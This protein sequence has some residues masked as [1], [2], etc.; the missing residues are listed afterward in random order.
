MASEPK[1]SVCELTT[2]GLSFDEEVA[3]YPQV[4]AQGIGIFEPK[5]PEGKDE[6]SLRKLREGGLKATICIPA[7]MS[8]LPLVK[9][10][11]PENPEER[12][13][14]MCA[15]IRRLAP[16]EPVSILC[17]TGAQGR[18][19]EPEARRIVVWG[20]R[21]VGRVAAEVGVPIGLEPLHTSMRED[22]TIAT[23]I[24]EAVDI[25]EEVGDPGFGIIFDTWHLWDTPNLYEDIRRHGHRLVRAI[26]ID[27]WRNTTRG[28]ND[29]A[30]PGEGIVDLPAIFGA[31]ESAGFDGWYDVEIFSDDGRFENDY[32]DSL[33]KLDP[34]ELISRSKAGFLRAWEARVVP[35]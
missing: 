33:W 32:E 21:E 24:E 27:D 9:F 2:I 5:L 15:G 19:S 1:F 23:T 3:L 28:W 14:A 29:R 22:W 20:L 7:I 31:L 16:F 17:L 8:V 11:G 26:H 18:W 13:E 10:P 34:A 12:V 35:V 4:G 30:L 25:L 6:D